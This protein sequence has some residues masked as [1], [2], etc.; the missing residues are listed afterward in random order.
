[1]TG[2]KKVGSGPA[3]GRM[4]LLIPT[5]EAPAS[6]AHED[7]GES[8]QAEQHDRISREAGELGQRGLE[9]Y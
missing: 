7:G 4:R 5:L 6:E 2:P 9:P 3:F 8:Q 1:M